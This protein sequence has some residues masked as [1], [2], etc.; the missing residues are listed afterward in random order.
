MEISRTPSTP[1][2]VRRLLF[3]APILL[4][5]AGLG[6]LLG[7]RFVLI[8]HV[9]RRT[10]TVHN[11]VVEVVRRD[12]DEVTV[13]AGFGPGSDWYRNLL[14]HPDAT[15]QIGSRRLP[16]TAQPV[17]ESAR[18]AAMLDY[19]RRHRH[20]APR[21]ARFMGFTIDG[22]DADFEAVGRALHMLRFTPR[23]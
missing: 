22:T 15:I 16:V 23:T 20:A 14:I 6:G 19:A 9:G 5:R 8:E 18:A 2:G 7:S 11:T 12:N 3:R 17:P 1:S 4:Y 13:A 10:G 21:L